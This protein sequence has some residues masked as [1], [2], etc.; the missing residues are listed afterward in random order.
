[1]MEEEVGREK[2]TQVGDWVWEFSLGVGPPRQSRVLGVCVSLGS[3]LKECFLDIIVS[4]R[5]MQGQLS[6]N[7]SL[8]P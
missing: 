5:E 4:P 2:I 6:C 8:L 1:M 7:P 3:S